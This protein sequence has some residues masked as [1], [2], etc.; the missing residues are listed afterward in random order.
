MLS[1]PYL[2]FGVIGYKVYRGFKAA[3]A[4]ARSAANGSG[5]GEALSSDAEGS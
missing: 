5:D 4:R 3:E 2:L 1:M